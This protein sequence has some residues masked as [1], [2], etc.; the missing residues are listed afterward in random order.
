[1]P[2]RAGD[3]A[4]DFTL[5]SHRGDAVRLSDAWREGPI[6][7]VFFPFAFSGRCQGELCEMRDNIGV[8]QAAGVRILGIS[9]DSTFA[10]GAWAEQQG[11]PFDLLADFW[12]H[13]EVA[14]AYDVFDERGGMAVR[15]SF[16]IDRHGVVRWSVVNDR[17]TV[18]ALDEYREALAAL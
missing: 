11:Y 13:G 9:V 10:L 16:L 12:P 18:R 14:R 5:P 2:I 6:V 3:Q 1:M 4:P 15:G 7:L 17:T 8:F